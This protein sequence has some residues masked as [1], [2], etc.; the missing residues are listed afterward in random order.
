MLLPRCD[1]TTLGLGFHFKT[2]FPLLVVARPGQR[3]TVDSSSSLNGRR[4]CIRLQSLS[5]GS[6]HCHRHNYISLVEGTEAG[7]RPGS[8]QQIPQLKLYHKVNHSRL[9]ATRGNLHAKQTFVC[10]PTV[11]CSRRC[12][13]CLDIPPQ[14]DGEQQL[15]ITSLTTYTAAAT[16]KS[17]AGSTIYVGH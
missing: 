3:Q 7:T 8:V 10:M 13:S 17:R 4:P 5:L 15:Q 11:Y 12:F 2:S 14:R 9:E 1:W 6:C 16:G